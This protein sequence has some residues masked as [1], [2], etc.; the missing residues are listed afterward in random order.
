VDAAERNTS[1]C[2]S[3]TISSRQVLPLSF[4]SLDLVTKLIPYFRLYFQFPFYNESESPTFIVLLA[5]IVPSSRLDSVLIVPDE[6]LERRVQLA[7]L[8]L[9]LPFSIYLSPF[10]LFFAV[11]RLLLLFLYQYLSFLDEVLSLENLRVHLT[12]LSSPLF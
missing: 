3:S 2:H 1:H 8:F 12:L 4:I 9:F 10:H 6:V 7:L 5:I 11:Y